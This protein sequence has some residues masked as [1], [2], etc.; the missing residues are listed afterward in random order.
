MVHRYFW[1]I[2]QQH[3]TKFEDYMTVVGSSDMHSFRSSDANAWTIYTRCMICFCI[4]CIDF[5]W[6]E[7]ESQQWVDE[8][9]C[10]PLIPLNTHQVPQALQ[11]AGSSDQMTT[12]PDFDQ[13]SYLIQQGTYIYVHAMF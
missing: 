3:L 6:N 10:I 4:S 2:E 5:A 1:L 11:L 12:S 8:W 9:T 13:V 7:C